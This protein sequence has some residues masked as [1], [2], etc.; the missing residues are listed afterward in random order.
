ML[1]VFSLLTKPICEQ[2]P[3]HHRP[4]REPVVVFLDAGSGAEGALRGV[5]AVGGDE[6]LYA[7]LHHGRVLFLRVSRRLLDLV[8]DQRD[9]QRELNRALRAFTSYM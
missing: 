1:C 4:R 3:T 9:L 2:P 5:R 8:V 6:L 7:A